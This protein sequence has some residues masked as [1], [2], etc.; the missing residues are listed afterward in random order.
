VM[1]ATFPITAQLVGREFLELMARS[2]ILENPPKH[3]CLSLYGDGFSEFIEGF[4]L[5]KSL[6]YLP[7]VARYELAINKAYYAKDD[8]ALSADALSV[9]APENLGDLKLKPRYSVHL[10]RSRYPLVKLQKF[11]M[12]ENQE[13]QFNMDQGGV[14]LMIYRP[15]LDTQ[16][17]ELGDDEYDILNALQCDET[18]GTA[19]ETVMNQHPNFDFQSFLQKH[20]SLET[21]RAFPANI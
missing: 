11:C 15:A 17:V 8:A 3:G 6:P 10:L 12:N 20:L 7:D 5:A 9:I 16:S 1:I 4:E 19:V 18:L 21:F 13:A 2:F 14:S